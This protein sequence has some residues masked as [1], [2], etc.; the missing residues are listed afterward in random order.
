MYVWRWPE[1]M[2]RHREEQ[3]SSEDES[4]LLERHPRTIFIQQWKRNG[5]ESKQNYVKN[6]RT[7]LQKSQTELW[8]LF[9]VFISNLS[10]FLHKKN[11]PQFLLH[12]SSRFFLLEPF[13]IYDWCMKWNYC[14][15]LSIF[16]TSFIPRTRRECTIKKV[17][18][19]IEIIKKKFLQK[20]PCSSFR[21]ESLPEQKYKKFFCQSHKNFVD[22]FF[23]LKTCC[24]NRKNIT[25]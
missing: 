13:P 17:A 9:A 7:A 12:F 18:W 19:K 20:F 10:Q 24:Y 1:K 21:Q 23:H 5:E 8:S 15:I 6:L 25:T 11:F 2:L 14:S 3:S 4:L 16:K 22:T